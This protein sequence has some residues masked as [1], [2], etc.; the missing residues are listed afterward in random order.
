MGIIASPYEKELTT[1]RMIVLLETAPFSNQ[2]HQMWFDQKQFTEISLAI[3]NAQPIGPDGVNKRVMVEGSKIH[4][5]S[6]E[7]QTH[8]GK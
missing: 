5:L 4:I 6:D 8:Y 7:I 2:Y 3:W 1:C